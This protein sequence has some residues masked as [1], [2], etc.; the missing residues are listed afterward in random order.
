MKILRNP[1]LWGTGALVVML[2]V[3]L[4]AALL[5]FSPPGSKLVTFYTNDASTLSPGTAVR[6]AGITVGKVKDLAIEPDQVRV[7]ASVDG[8]AFIGDQSQVQI[9]MLTVVG[10]YYV[11]I[12][13]LG[14]VPLGARAIPLERVVP[15]YNLIR[16]L[17]DATA[18]TEKIDTPP[19]NDS[20]DQLQKGLSGPNLDSITSVVHAGQRLTAVLDRQRGQLSRILNISD[21][22]IAA[23]SGYRDQLQAM[24]RKVA[25]LEQTLTLYGKGFEAALRG[26]GQ[27]LQGIGPI[28]EF[29][30][31]HRDVALTR[32]IHWQQIF[33]SWSDRNGVVVRWLRRVRDRMEQALV[34]QGSPPELLATDL[35]IPVPGSPC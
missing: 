34:R 10:G 19:I 31:S 20:L 33:R 17:T 28:G 12:E 4:V 3:A 29:Y 7:R 32:F 11:N 8:N 22:Y 14:D 23:L 6:I 5:Y 9:R 30:M 16:T 21:E 2:A 35:C 18:V 26:M 25:I 27:I 24:I 1:T 15:P 13:S